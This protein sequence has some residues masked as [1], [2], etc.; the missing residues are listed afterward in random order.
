MNRNEKQ[1]WE[2]VRAKGHS[3]FIFREL[4][5]EGLPFGFSMTLASIVWDLLAHNSVKPL[6]LTVTFAFFVFTFGY[7]QGETRWRHF[8]EDYQD[9]IS[10]SD[11]GGKE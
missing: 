8:E 10:R 2:Q 9:L 5:R 3:Q 11:V 4:W 6:D 1:K 7:M